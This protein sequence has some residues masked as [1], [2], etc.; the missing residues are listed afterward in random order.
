MSLFTIPFGISRSRKGRGGRRS[1]WRM[2]RRRRRRKKRR[3]KGEVE[4][5]GLK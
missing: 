1:I 5:K 2:R 3:R 4:L